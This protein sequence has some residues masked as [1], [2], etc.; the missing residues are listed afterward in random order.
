MGFESPFRCR[1]IAAFIL[2]DGLTVLVEN[3]G[4]FILF[5]LAIL[6]GPIIAALAGYMVFLGHFD[7]VSALVVLI[8]ADL[9]GDI[10]FYRL[11]MVAKTETGRK[12]LKRLR[13]RDEQLEYFEAQ[14]A[15]RGGTIIM[16]GKIL[17]APGIVTL[18]A[19]GAVHMNL[20]KFLFYNFVSATPKLALMHYLG[21]HLGA[22][23]SEVEHFVF[24]YGVIIGGV[25]IA[26]A[27]AWWHL[28]PR[29]K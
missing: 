5:P 1:L 11:G 15:Y 4:L 21:Y 19:A 2:H 18:I 8:L 27:L 23:F 7:A 22:R 29:K 3:Y 16:L 20:V 12:W 13:I 17:H 6:E 26:I 28:H 9:A 25:L 10:I 14:F 24:D